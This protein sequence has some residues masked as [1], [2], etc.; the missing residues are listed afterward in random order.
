MRRR[1]S[2]RCSP[3]LVSGNLQKHA[4]NV[5][6]STF[7]LPVNTQHI[8]AQSNINARAFMSSNPHQISCL[9]KCVWGKEKVPLFSLSSSSFWGGGFS[10]SLCATFFLFFQAVCF[11]W[12]SYRERSSSRKNRRKGDRSDCWI[13]A[14]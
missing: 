7:T 1:S 13:W 2:T 3:P 4:P 10:L 14:G 6:V 11:H 5:N 12:L 8:N 9:G